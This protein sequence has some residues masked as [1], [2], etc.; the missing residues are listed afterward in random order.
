MIQ[1]QEA[2]ETCAQVVGAPGTLPKSAFIL[3]GRHETTISICKMNS[4]SLHSC[5]AGQFEV[6][7]IPGHR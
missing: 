7:G 5:E 1:P 2:L 6:G 4:D 3:L